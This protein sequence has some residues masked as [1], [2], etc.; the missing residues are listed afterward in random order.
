VGASCEIVLV[1]DLIQASVERVRGTPGQVLSRHPHEACFECSFRLPIAIPDSVVQAIDRV[2]R[3]S[4]TRKR[5]GN[6]A[7]MPETRSR[8]DFV[9][10]VRALSQAA[11]SGDAAQM[12]LDVARYLEAVSAWTHDMPGWFAN[13]GQPLPEPSWSLFANI[14]E[15]ALTYE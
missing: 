15:A 3:Q 1:E 14:L 10:I 13:E 4:T 6:D 12:N 11:Q 8:E 2:D 5:G 7:E 9:K